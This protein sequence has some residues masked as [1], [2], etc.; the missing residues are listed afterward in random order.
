MLTMSSKTGMFIEEAITCLFDQEQVIQYE[1][2]TKKKVYKR[3]KREVKGEWPDEQ[4]F[5]LIEMVE[6]RPDLWDSSLPSYRQTK[7]HVSV[8]L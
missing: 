1:P 5:R 7:P 2:P 8:Y 3:R 4:I 6:Q